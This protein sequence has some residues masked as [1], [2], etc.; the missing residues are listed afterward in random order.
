MDRREGDEV[1]DYTY[2]LLW[3]MKSKVGED[4]KNKNEW[5]LN[6][7]SMHK[8]RGKKE[9]T[10]V[11]LLCTQTKWG[12]D[13]MYYSLYCWDDEVMKLIKIEKMRKNMK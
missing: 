6:D 3:M 7:R 11:K 2:S 13:W 4:E 9:K 1:E 8:D 12:V 10:Q 5:W